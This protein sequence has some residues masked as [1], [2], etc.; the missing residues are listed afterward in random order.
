MITEEDHPGAGSTRVAQLRA[1][2]TGQPGSSRRPAETAA[3]T[4]Q[5]GTSPSSN[6]VPAAAAAA[7]TAASASAHAVACHDQGTG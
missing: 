3:A 5:T 6:R 4:C 2:G 1:A 7:F